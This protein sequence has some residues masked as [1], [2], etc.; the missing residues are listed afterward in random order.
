MDGLTLIL[1]AHA[2]GMTVTA[3]GATLVVKGPKHQ[4]DLARLLLANKPVTIAAL[5]DAG[6]KGWSL[7]WSD[8]ASAQFGQDLALDPTNIPQPGSE[9]WMAS[10]CRAVRDD[11]DLPRSICPPEKHDI[12]DMII[13][14][15]VPS[16]VFGPAAVSPTTDGTG[17]TVA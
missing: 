14:G 17:V 5:L 4:A 16:I 6:V 12:I 2:T 11:A 7:T 3:N 15:A 13:L 1:A 8:E 9:L 10:V